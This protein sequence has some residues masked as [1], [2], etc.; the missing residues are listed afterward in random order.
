MRNIGVESYDSEI[1]RKGKNLLLR[2]RHVSCVVANSSISFSQISINMRMQYLKR[3]RNAQRVRH[4]SLS[5]DNVSKYIR[6]LLQI[7]FSTIKTAV[8]SISQELEGDRRK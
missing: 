2:K 7:T 5:S 1:K 4:S 3:K 8:S 6:K